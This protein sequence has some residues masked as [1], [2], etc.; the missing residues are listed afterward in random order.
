MNW[1]SLPKTP[2]NWMLDPDLKMIGVSAYLPIVNTSERVN[3]RNMSSL[4]ATTVKSAL[5][6]FATELGEPIFISEV[7]Y[8]NSSNALYQPWASTNSAPADPEEQA[9]AY[10]AVLANILVDPQILG[11]FFWG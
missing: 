8:R 10:K 5:D 7:G 4:W 9:A 1:T 11:S 2:P 6:A 3:P